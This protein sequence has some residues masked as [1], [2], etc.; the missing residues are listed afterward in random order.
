LNKLAD[1]HPGHHHHH[2]L[3]LMW[4][5]LH[6]PLHHRHH[7]RCLQSASDHQSGHLLVLEMLLLLLRSQVQQQQQAGRQRVRLLLQVLGFCRCCFAGRR[8]VSRM[9][10][11]H[12]YH[13]P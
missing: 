3:L 6:A 10:T 1:Q 2:L 13:L 8:G 11:A 9:V 5:C 12:H 7:T 4:R